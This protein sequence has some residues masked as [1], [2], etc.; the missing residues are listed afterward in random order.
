M[1]PPG[2]EVI[3]GA[4]RDDSFGPVVM[5]GLRGTVTEIL[6]DLLTASLRSY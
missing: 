4:Y 6:N 2:L 1:A 5:A 3:V